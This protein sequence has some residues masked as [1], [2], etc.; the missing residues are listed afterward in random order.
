MQTAFRWVL[1]ETRE[2]STKQRRNRVTT[3]GPYD[4]H[5]EALAAMRLW[6]SKTSRNTIRSSFLLEQVC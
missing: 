5:E 6:V 2:C 3:H 4:T 1:V